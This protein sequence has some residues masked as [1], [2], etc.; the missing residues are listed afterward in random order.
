MPVYF[1]DV[2]IFGKGTGQPD[3]WVKCS[4]AVVFLLDYFAGIVVDTDYSLIIFWT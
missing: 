1:V 3:N 4:L 2:C